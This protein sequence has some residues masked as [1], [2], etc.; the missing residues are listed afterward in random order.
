MK[1]FFI[2]LITLGV[3]AAGVYVGG[4]M[5]IEM[6]TES[7][8][9]E[10]QELKTRLVDLGAYV[11]EER[12]IRESGALPTEAGLPDVI[13]NFNRIAKRLD[14]LEKKV[15]VET[16]SRQMLEEDVHKAINQMVVKA[17]GVVDEKLDAVSGAFVQKEAGFE[18]MVR[19][20]ESGFRQLRFEQAVLNVMGHLN[21]AKA[22]IL[23]RNVGKALGKLDLAR[24]RLEQLKKEA[25]GNLGATVDKL[26]AS[27]QALRQ[28]VDSG[29]PS[30]VERIDILWDDMERLSVL[31]TAEAGA[32][33]RE[34]AGASKSAPVMK[35]EAKTGSRKTGEADAG[36]PSN[37][38]EAQKTGSEGGQ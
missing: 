28:D 14:N 11:D 19:S 4:P 6:Q 8:R 7:M 5:L 27:L 31:S 23:D 38:R 26:L 36:A 12:A 30:S 17:E 16:Q 9:A 35:K 21:K 1:Y 3:A 29:R 2:I 25:P 20:V 18:G 32:G 33:S 13:Q 22:D 15:E 37:D 10:I 34:V 24:T